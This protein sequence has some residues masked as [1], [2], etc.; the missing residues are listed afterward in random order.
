MKCTTHSTKRIL[1][2]LLLTLALACPLHTHGEE[3]M[4]A[5]PS[6]GGDSADLAQDLTNPLADLITL[7]IQANFDDGFGPLGDGWKLQTNIQPVIPFQLNEHWNLIT[8][9]IIPVIHQEDLFPGSG[10]QFGLGDTNMSLF[11][12]PTPSE[13][14]FMWGAGPVMLF[15]TATD[16]LLGADKW[17]AGPSLVML[18]MQGPWTYGVLAN[19]VWSF[20]GSGDRSIN[21]TFVQPF[22]SYTTE[23]AWTFSLQSETNYDWNAD[24][25][26]IPVNFSVSK[27]VV[28]GK[29]P[30]S[31]QA[32]LG[33]WAESATNGP[34]GMRFRLQVNIVLP[35]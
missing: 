6:A 7:P 35:K 5:P 34:D 15:P 12:S 33:Y 3:T 2:A 16:S 13:D 23:D 8:R 17:S 1:P 22:V 26:T 19:H 30:V 24:Q 27:L 11:F 32:G 29:L 9:T 31:L 20:A 21:N 18:R 4:A 28:I 10:S 25:V 14:G